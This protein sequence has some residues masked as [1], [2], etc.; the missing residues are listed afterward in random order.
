[1]TKN[2]DVEAW[3][4]IAHALFHDLKPKDASFELCGDGMKKGEFA[5]LVHR[6]T[7]RVNEA[8]ITMSLA[9]DEHEVHQI[10]NNLSKDTVT[11]LF[12]RWAH[13]YAAWKKMENEAHPH[14]WIPPRD[15]WRAIFLGMT[16]DVPAASEACKRIWPESFQG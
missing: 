6:E 15:I 2:K 14:L 13:Y 8:L 10:F 16:D 5:F 9:K 4:T 3:L 1:M 7:K 11:A 12:S